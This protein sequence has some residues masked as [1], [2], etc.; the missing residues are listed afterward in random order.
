MSLPYLWDYNID[1]NEF[2]ASLEGELT[3][4]FPKEGD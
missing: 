4:D 3:I 2:L 1:E